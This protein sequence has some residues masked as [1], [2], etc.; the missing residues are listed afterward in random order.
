MSPLCKE[1]GGIG[2]TIQP[3]RE[4]AKAYVC[5]CQ[6]NCGRCD[7]T[8][9]VLV[10]EDGY[11]VARPCLCQKLSLRVARFNHAGIPAPYGVKTVSSFVTT[12][13]THA[14]KTK[15]TRYKR[16]FKPND[17]RGVLL[18]GAPGTGKT[19]LLC[20]LLHYLTLEKGIQC[21]MVDFFELTARI[22]HTYGGG[23]GEDEQDILE[24]LV[25]V[26]VLA[27]DE[28]GKGRGTTWELS[29][30]DQLISRRY[31]AGRV[32]LATS[33][34]LPSHLLDT[35]G[36]RSTNHQGERLGA[37]LEERVGAR[38]FSRLAEM[39]EIELIRG[40]DYRQRHLKPPQGKR[41]SSSR[42]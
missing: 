19:H 13:S 18:V 20:G 37:S 30:V 26:P 24:P 28:L 5:S 36:T 8:G 31:N 9:Y 41:G 29:I 11:E 32:V 4:L 6:V 17:A 1:C 7:G 33:N 39:C 38:I 16:A 23:T 12:S 42:S 35:P 22:R 27:I 2:Y 3:G 15:L 25:N 14:L 40:E 10:T 21:Q 34:Y